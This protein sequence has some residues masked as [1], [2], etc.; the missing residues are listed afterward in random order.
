[1]IRHPLPPPPPPAEIPP[2][3]IRVCAYY[4]WQEAGCPDGR[5]LEFWHG[6]RE[7]LGRLP[8]F[9]DHP[10]QDVRTTGQEAR[11][12]GGRLRVS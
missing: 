2:E 4:L 12:Y 8:S 7:R 11:R 5:D 6:A 1:M 9:R 3:A 10:R